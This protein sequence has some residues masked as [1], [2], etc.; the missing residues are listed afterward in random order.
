[1][2]RALLFLAGFGALASALA[3]LPLPRGAAQEGGGDG[4]AV[5]AARLFRSRCASCHVIPD[6]QRATD[7]AWIGQIAVTA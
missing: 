3:L 5:E 2:R 1:M 7:Q 6:P 4:E